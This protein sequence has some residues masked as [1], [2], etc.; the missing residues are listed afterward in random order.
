MVFSVMMGQMDMRENRLIFVI[1]TGR[2]GTHLI[3]R[4]ISSHPEI[5]GRIEDSETF[6]LITR[7]GTQQDIRSRIHNFL[8][9][10]WLKTRLNGALNR[11]QFHILEKAHPSIWLM[12]WL[13][14]EFT[15]S[16]FIGVWRDVEPTVSSMLLHEGVLSWY[17]RLPQDRPNRFLGITT[18]NQEVF[19][20]F[21]I[22]EK[23]ALRW[24]SHKNE[25]MRLKTEYP[26]DLLLIK[27]EDF[28]NE[29]TQ[30]LSDI[31]QFV[32]VSDTF[33][34]E[35]FKKDSLEKWK[36]HLNAEQIKRIRNIVDS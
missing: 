25:L 2:S 31:A 5:E 13:K 14:L 24:M 29:P 17:D 21:S 7:L 22:E 18:Q 23:C 32:G 16:K 28:L 12:Q 35:L 36:A 26:D 19:R 20:N 3:G 4:A 9:R 11:S 33:T 6:D 8:V 30:N 1:G 15:G 27:Y 10:V 34:P